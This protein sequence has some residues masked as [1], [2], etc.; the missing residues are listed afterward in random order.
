VLHNLHMDPFTVP[1]EIVTLLQG[2][3]AGAV[4]SARHRRESRKGRQEAYRTFQH[5]AYRLMTSVVHLNTYTQ[6]KTITL[7]TGFVAALPM[8]GRMLNFLQL[9]LADFLRSKK[10]QQYK[11]LRNLERLLPMAAALIQ[12]NTPMASVSFADAL[13]ADTL[14][15]YRITGDFGALREATADFLAA[16]AKVRLT[17]TPGPI[18]AADVIREALQEL[19][20]KLSSKKK[21]LSVS[22]PHKDSRPDHLTSDFD[23]Y[24]SVLIEAQEQFICATQADRPTRRHRWQLWRPTKLP[25]KDV[26]Q[27]LA[28]IRE[29]RR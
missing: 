13:G 25:V 15:V 1:A 27:L 26:R 2:A 12:A 7:K 17:G 3:A 20:S 16:L 24:L 23:T 18:A 19:F 8:A 14:L 11:F 28:E 4:P 21:R 9:E 6:I 22:I 10:R 29:Q 5:E